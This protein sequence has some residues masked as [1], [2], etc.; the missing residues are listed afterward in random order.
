MKKAPDID[1]Q[2][3][4]KDTQMPTGL[5]TKSMD[6]QSLVSSSPSKV[7]LSPRVAKKKQSIVGLSS[8]EAKYKGVAEAACEAVWLKRTLKDLGVPIKYLIPLY[9]DNMSSIHLA[10]KPGVPRTHEA[11]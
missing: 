1:S 8:I 5:A 9:Y 10:Q 2:F 11:Y 3:D 7:E 6:D 4:W